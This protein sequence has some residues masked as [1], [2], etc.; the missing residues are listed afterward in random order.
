[1]SDLQGF[2]EYTPTDKENNL[3]EVMLN[4]EHRMKSIS[5]IC[6]LANC[7]RPIYYDAFNKPGFVKL[8]E[9]KSKE[10]IKQS[11]APVI[12]TFIREAQRGSFQHGKVILEMAG[13]YSEKQQ[14]DIG[15]KDGQSFKLNIAEMSTEE[16]EKQA[17]ELAKKIASES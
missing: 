15:N 12:N 2:T 4:P 6:K 1:M 9:A 7:S 16:L 17:K 14:I 10:L 8:Y 5:D 3:L 11:V 13:I